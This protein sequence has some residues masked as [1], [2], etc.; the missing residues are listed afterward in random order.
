MAGVK[1]RILSYAYTLDDTVDINDAK[2]NFA[3]DLL[4]DRVLAYTNRQQFVTQYERD[5]ASRSPDDPAWQD[6]W[7]DYD[8]YPIPPELERPMAVALVQL[9]K[10]FDS[11]LNGSREAV[12][13]SD[14]DQSVEFGTGIAATMASGDA[15]AVLELLPM[16]DRYKVVKVIASP[17]LEQEDSD[18]YWQ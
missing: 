11:T 15:K 4:I 18:E 8:R 10:G 5:Q 1:E 9:L 2:V 14:G 12:R 13:V 3:V 17:N 7:R 6:F 16:L